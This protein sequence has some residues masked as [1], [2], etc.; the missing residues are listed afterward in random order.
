[1][2]LNGILRMIA[3]NFL[4]G[5]VFG[6]ASWDDAQKNLEHAVALDSNRITHRL[7][8][9]AVY[10]DRHL[11]QQAIEQYEW[12]ARAPISDFNDGHYKDQAARKLA[13]LR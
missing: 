12:I 8:L 7:D 11:R 10:V 3:K 1:M 9:G 6:E 13:E 4:G 5:Q 2:R